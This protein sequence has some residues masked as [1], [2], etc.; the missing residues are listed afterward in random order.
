M[1]RASVQDTEMEMI[2]DSIVDSL[3]SVFSTLGV[4]PIIRCS[5]GNAA[6]HVAEKL[7]KKIRDNLRDLRNSPFMSDPL[8]SG[9]G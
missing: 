6:E 4:V 7:D 3:F 5:K 1:N 8:A 9:Y 2:L